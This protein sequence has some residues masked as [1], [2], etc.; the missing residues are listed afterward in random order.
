MKKPGKTAPYGRGSESWFCIHNNLPSRD[1]R[2]RSNVSAA[3]GSA[4]TQIGVTG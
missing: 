4:T 1:H 3:R 2:E